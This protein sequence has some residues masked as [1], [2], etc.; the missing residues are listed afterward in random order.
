MMKKLT[1]DEVVVKNYIESNLKFLLEARYKVINSGG[2]PTVV[3]IGD[4][5]PRDD[6]EIW[7]SPVNKVVGSVFGMKIIC[8]HRVPPDSFYVTSGDLSHDG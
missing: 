3:Y 2:S 6:F 8:D 4:I 5:F 1:K 7:A